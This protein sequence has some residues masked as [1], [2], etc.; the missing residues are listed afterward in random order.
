VKGVYF[1]KTE[2]PCTGVK[3]FYQ[4]ARYQIIFNHRDDD[5]DE[6]RDDVEDRSRDTYNE[7]KFLSLNNLISSSV[8]LNGIK[9]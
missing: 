4:H 5:D 6:D 3:A 1:Y 9:N 8:F 7:R 2:I